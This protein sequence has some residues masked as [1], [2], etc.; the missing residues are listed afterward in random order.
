MQ[1]LIVLLPKIVTFANLI[2]MV[3]LILF[4][5]MQNKNAGMSQVFGGS[6]NIT[7]TRRGVE[8]WL[9]YSTIV[10]G[11]LFVGLSLGSLFIK[12]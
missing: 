6:G 4:I 5:S 7:Q 1:K 11:V 10:L 3:I 2:V 8:K 12:K 9:F